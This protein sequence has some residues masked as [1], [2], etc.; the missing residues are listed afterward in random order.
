[1]LYYTNLVQPGQANQCNCPQC[2]AWPGPFSV[3]KYSNFYKALQ[4][5]AIV[6][7]Y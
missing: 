4:S 2:P 3:L 5:M 6:Q 7:R 1:M